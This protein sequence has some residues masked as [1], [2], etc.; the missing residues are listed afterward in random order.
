MH[1][2]ALSLRG[3]LRA[4]SSPS[5]GVARSPFDSGDPNY[6]RT[7]CFVY[8][9]PLPAGLKVSREW[10]GV[11][12][13]FVGAIIGTLRLIFRRILGTRS[14]V[15]IQDHDRLFCFEFVIQVLQDA[16]VAGA[17]DLVP[18]NTTPAMIRKWLLR[19]KDFRKVP[20][21]QF[22]D[23]TYELSKPAAVPIVGR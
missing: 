18:E 3:F 20:V 17:V 2:E 22:M 13:D 1:V 5:T 6:L 14:R 4:E 19:H 15:S 10:I 23:G 12:Y 21:E 7:E 8:V 9:G 11:S 16:H